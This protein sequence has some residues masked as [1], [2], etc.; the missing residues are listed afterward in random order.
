MVSDAPLAFMNEQTDNTLDSGHEGWKILIVDDDQDVHS[1]TEL[2]MHG[3]SILG[4]SLVF[5]HAY[6]A[7][8]ARVV[9]QE[10]SDIAVILLDVVMESENAGLT[11]VHTVREEM[12]LRAT[13]IILRTGQPGYAPEYEAIRD[14]DINDYRTK[15][16]LSYARLLTSLTA[17]I[18]SYTQI[19]TISESTNILEFIIESAP[20]LLA[21]SS[22]S[23]F[24]HGVLSLLEGVMEHPIDALL[25]HVPGEDLAGTPDAYPAIHGGCGSWQSIEHHSLQE[26]LSD[27]PPEIDG[28]TSDLVRQALKLRNHRY[29]TR[30]FVLH[31]FGMEHGDLLLL[32]RQKP[33]LEPEQKRLL[34]VFAVAVS[35][36]YQNVNLVTQLR[37][38]AFKDGLTGLL[39]R[40]GLIQAINHFRKE[41][42][43]GQTIALIDIEGFS[44]LNE[45]LGHEYGDALLVAVARRITTCFDEPVVCARVGADGFVV[46]GRDI[47]INPVVITEIFAKPFVVQQNSM[48]LRMV[49]GF[50][51]LDDV[52]GDGADMIKD[53]YLAVKSAKF[54]RQTRFAYYNPRA[55]TENRNR[56]IMLQ[57]LQ[58]GLDSSALS[59]HYQ[60]QIN[61]VSKKVTGFEALLRWK[62]KDG[63][64][65]PPAMFIPLAEQSG[66][67]I[68]M[69]DWLIKEVLGQVRTWNAQGLKD[70]R[71][72]INISVRQF[73]NPSFISYLLRCMEQYEV[74]TSQIELEV[75]ESMAMNAIDEV[76]DMLGKLKDH[77]FMIALDDFGTGFSS[78][79]YLQ[80]LPIDRIKIDRAFVS[81]IHE[82]EKHRTIA[83]TI[84]RL[85]QSLGLDLIAE[86]VE[87][88]AQADV[89][90]D[91][92]CQE[93]QG[94]FY[95][96]PMDVGNCT[97]WIHDNRA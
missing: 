20:D 60:P 87:E 58:T 93:A 11:L 82:A 89:L 6:S 44:E 30:S 75:T 48:Y 2:V 35:M 24:E 22:F 46:M 14:Y 92:G 71:V 33:I 97:K 69:G 13:R 74:P 54:Q 83:Q 72:A 80:K 8:Q 64:F 76:I 67:I 36:G 10:Q 9:L 43:K 70:F 15:S 59:V 50:V 63:T 57:E 1:V 55:E 85:G 29:S 38:L 73:Y 96:K 28:E 95:G 66:L 65:V 19:K 21:K 79:S 88:Q 5:L 81:P 84:V 41:G 40:T 62:K 31:F 3:V 52:Q 27:L 42:H 17:A 32:V 16:E 61:M 39:N 68:E 26:N 45:V 4:R 34:E 37:V 77:G 18:R 7:A 86:G 23:D 78:L 53:A 12:N 91:L 47:T 90:I 51:R 25:I 49:S 56:V 94:Y